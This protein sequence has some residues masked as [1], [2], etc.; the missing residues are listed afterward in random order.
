M[1]P[2]PVAKPGKY[3]GTGKREKIIILVRNAIE[4]FCFQN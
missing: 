4:I 3:V 2:I 1:K